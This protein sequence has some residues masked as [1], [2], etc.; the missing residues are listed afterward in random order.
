[1]RL[2]NYLHKH[3][4]RP[5][6][7]QEEPSPK[8]G[9]VVVIPAH[10]EEEV[11]S[12]VKS[13]YQCDLPS[14]KVEIIVVFNAS[15]Q[16]E[17][18]LIA[19]N[20]KAAD[21][22][23]TWSED[24]VHEQIQLHIIEEN[25]LPHKH[26]G[27]GLARKI[28]MDE[29]VRR[30]E[31]SNHEDGIIVCFDADSSGEKNYLIQIENHFERHPK[32]SACSIHFEHP[33]EGDEFSEIHYENI[34]NYELHLRYYKNGLAYAGLPYA[35]HTIGSSMAV[36]LKD[37]CSQGGMNRRKAGED[38]YFLQK[39][40]DLG[41]FSEINSTKVIPSARSSDRVPFGT[42]RA[43]KEALNG[44]KKLDE[45]Y[46]FES[47]K[48]LKSCFANIKDWYISSNRP[49]FHESLI[50]FEGKDEL[51]KKLLEIKIQSSTYAIFYKRF[52]LWFNAFKTL[53]FIHFLRD[54]YYPMEKLTKAVPS[55]L[56]GLNIEFEEGENRALLLRLRELDKSKK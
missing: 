23:R 18:E 27:V 33:I 14:Q 11:I 10:N 5:Q 32:T 34:L 17:A 30:F 3:A 56:I 9:M 42:G 12:A 6:L 21:Q 49:I 41:N 40:I 45:T 37:Y 25:A 36:R 48:I 46:A 55:L 54:Q 28:G 38:F 13:L 31:S 50:A 2:S 19:I 16:D 39:F 43:I 52:F 20:R 47:L 8:L 1:M 7:I 26:A 15:E 24:Q 53:K 51:E 44:T 35:Y 4:F 29:A 22:L